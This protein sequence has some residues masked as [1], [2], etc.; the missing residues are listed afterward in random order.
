MTMEEVIE[1]RDAGQMD[2]DD[3]TYED[4]IAVP[5]QKAA[6]QQND[7]NTLDNSDEE[8]SDHEY[9]N[10]TILSDNQSP[11]REAEDDCLQQDSCDQVYDQPF[12]NN[13]EASATP[14]PQLVLSRAKTSSLP[15][16]INSKKDARPT[17]VN[18]LPADAETTRDG[19]LQ[20]RSCEQLDFERA[21][22]HTEPDYLT[23]LDE[24]PKSSNSLPTSHSCSFL[25]AKTSEGATNQQHLTDGL[26]PDT[27]KRPASIVL[28][29]NPSYEPNHQ[30]HQSFQDRK[31]K[32]AP[33]PRHFKA[34]KHKN[35]KAV[36]RGALKFF[37][38]KTP[39]SKVPQTTN[40][41]TSHTWGKP[42][43]Y[44]INTNVPTAKSPSYDNLEVI[45]TR[46]RAASHH[47]DNNL[48]DEEEIELTR[49][50][51]YESSEVVNFYRPVEQNVARVLSSEENDEIYV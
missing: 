42:I 45:S 51:S 6:A 29:P 50:P 46:H 15:S 7:S 10:V 30:F 9:G 4:T 32:T 23:L 25:S 41:S 22:S 1:M 36:N 21:R 48:T 5:P 17:Y 3:N 40:P 35:T 34:Q 27:S 8:E 11:H 12:M 47:S 37:S 28:S 2:M 26:K 33:K 14:T 19:N 38:T 39:S 24:Q 20:A 16:D 18:L 31:P 49:N 44:S 43:A 13:T